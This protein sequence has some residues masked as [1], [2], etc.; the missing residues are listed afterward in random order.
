MC[1]EGNE[2]GEIES[3]QR[4]DEKQIFAAGNW[5]DFEQFAIMI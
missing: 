2:R 3:N 4:E 1:R 5:S